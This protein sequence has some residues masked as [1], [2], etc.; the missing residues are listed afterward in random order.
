MPQLR[1]LAKVLRSKTVGPF[2]LTLD[3]MFD[4]NTLYEQIKDSGV[5]NKDIVGDL[6]RVNPQEVEIITHDLVKTIKVNIPRRI[7][8]G[9]YDDTDIFGMMQYIPLAGIEVGDA[10]N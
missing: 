2:R 8:S 3:V 5:I 9:N 1:E 7:P 10:V 6:Y 4:D